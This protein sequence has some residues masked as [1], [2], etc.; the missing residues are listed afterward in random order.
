MVI[1]VPRV[2]GVVTVATT[3]AVT[4]SL[5][6]NVPMFHVSK[7]PPT[8]GVGALLIVVAMATLRR[9]GDLRHG[10]DFTS[11]TVLV[12]GGIYSLVRHPL[13]LGWLLMYPSA[14]LVSQHWM[15]VIVGVLGVVSIDQI[16]R[17][18]DEQLSEKFGVD[19][20]RYMLEVPRLNAFLGIARRLRRRN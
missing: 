12:K 17:L 6:V 9:A 5:L 11:T 1:T 10:D 19:Y 2:N 7:P 13:Y 14:M 18:A 8:V 20:E 15:I 3:V 4:V 16:T